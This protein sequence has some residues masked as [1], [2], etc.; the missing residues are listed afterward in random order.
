[1][2]H[3]FKVERQVVVLDPQAKAVAPEPVTLLL[4]QAADMTPEQA[5]AALAP[6]NLSEEHRF[7]RRPLKG[8]FLRL[9]CTGGLA[10]AGQRSAGVHSGLAHAAQAQ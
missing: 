3:T 6:N 4:H 8:H 2:S 7:G 1:M 5:L 10:S 9:S